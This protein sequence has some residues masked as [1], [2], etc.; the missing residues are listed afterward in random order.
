MTV[1]LLQKSD[2]FLDLGG[3]GFPFN[4]AGWTD[5]SWVL[6]IETFAI[7]TE[8]VR[9]FG[10]KTPVETIGSERILQN[11]ANI[12]AQSALHFIKAYLAK[13]S[14]NAVKRWSRG[15]WS[16]LVICFRYQQRMVTGY[17]EWFS[18]GWTT[19]WGVM[20]CESIPCLSLNSMAM[21]DG[22]CFSICCR[23]STQD[24]SFCASAL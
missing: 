7:V 11:I 24:P 2:D 22:Q 4:I 6:C 17:I 9:V 21:R 10:N 12:L 15:F 3:T 20:A 5:K 8:T 14:R 16:I 13:Q 1:Y 23:L 18:V 19:N